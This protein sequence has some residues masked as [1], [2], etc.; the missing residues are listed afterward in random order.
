MPV[1]DYADVGRLTG[2]IRD[3]RMA[4]TAASAAKQKLTLREL[5][6]GAELTSGCL[7]GCVN[8]CLMRSM[9]AGP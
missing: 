9:P 2:Q 3:G 7:P 5:G 4:V 1:A 8:S 6:T